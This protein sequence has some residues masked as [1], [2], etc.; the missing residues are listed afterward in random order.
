MTAWDSPDEAR[1]FAAA[2]PS[3]AAAAR[4]ERREDRVLVLTSSENLDLDALAARVWGATDAGS[5]PAD[6]LREPPHHA[7]HDVP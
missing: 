6:T 4:V 2:M 5:A 3:I 7:R 1:E